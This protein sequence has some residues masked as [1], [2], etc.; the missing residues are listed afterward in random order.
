MFIFLT[1]LVPVSIG[2]VGTDELRLC[3][4]LIAEQPR[5]D[6]GLSRT[7]GDEMERPHALF[8]LS[9]KTR[10]MLAVLAV[11]PS[12]IAIRSVVPAIVRR[13]SRSSIES[14]QRLPPRL[15]QSPDWMKLAQ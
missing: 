8:P 14:S 3:I 5:I 1:L 11:T 2:M 13:Q 7:D 4:D 6:A 15:A 10:R 12:V 9:L